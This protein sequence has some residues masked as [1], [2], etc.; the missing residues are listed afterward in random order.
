MRISIGTPPVPVLGIADTGSDLTWVQ[1]KP[2]EECFE[3]NAPLFDPRKSSTYKNVLCGSN[4]CNELDSS[5]RVCDVVQDQNRACKYSYSYGDHSFTKGNVALE[6]FNIGGDSSAS[7]PN[8]LVFGCGHNNGG[9]FDYAGSGIVGLGGGPLSLIKQLGKSIN[10]KFSYCLAPPPAAESTSSS[11]STIT[12][13]TPTLT[14]TSS[15]ESNTKKHGETVSTPLV[16]KTPSTYYYVKLEAVSVG[17]IR[18]DYGGSTS[19]TAKGKAGG[20]IIIDSGTTLTLLESEFYNSLES[21]V[22]ESVEAKRVSDPKGLFSPCFEAGGTDNIQFPIITFHFSGADLKLK[23]WNTFAQ[24]EENMVC[25]TIIPSNDIAIL[26]NL[27]QMDFLVSYDL[28]ER[29]VSFTPTDCT[30]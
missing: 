28:E 16:D 1:C 4:S 24:V 8:Q 9:T 14:S 5:A 25:F 2:C 11:S 15:S 18:L 29:T 19:T 27:S 12:F 13:G 17:E 21:A 10:G 30:V 3:Q 23:P 22:E 20:N 26:G 6:K 7:F